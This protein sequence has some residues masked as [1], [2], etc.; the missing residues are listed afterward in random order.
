M[1]FEIARQQTPLY[2]LSSFLYNSAQPLYL[3]AGSSSVAL[4]CFSVDSIGLWSWIRRTERSSSEVAIMAQSSFAMRQ[5][6]VGG[7]EPW[8][9]SSLVHYSWL[10]H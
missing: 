5:R 8:R 9:I 10:A 3:L 6:K 7:P 4:Q 2:R 1:K